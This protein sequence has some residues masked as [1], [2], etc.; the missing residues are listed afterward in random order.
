MQIY[1]LEQIITPGYDEYEAKVIIANK[2]IE[3]RILA[4]INTGDEGKIWKNPILVSCKE[5]DF[6][7]SGVVLEAFK[8]G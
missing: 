4:N 5:V 2:P 7:I 3:A 8:G 6:N 1:L